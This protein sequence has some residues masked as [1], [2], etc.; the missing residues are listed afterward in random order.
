MQADPQYAAEIQQFRN[1]IGQYQ[2]TAP[3]QVVR[4]IPVVVHV[5]YSNASENVSNTVI[6]NMITTI[7]ED[8]RRQN[9]DTT[10]TTTAFQGIAVDAQIEFCLA[11]TDP[12]GQPTTGIT[13][14]STST[15]CWNQSTQTNSMKSSSTGGA[16]PWPSTDYLNIWICDICPN[17]GGSGVA[18]YAYLPTPGMHGSSIDGLVLDY[19]IGLGTTQW[20]G[21]DRTATHELGHYFG[22]CHPWGCNNGGCGDDDNI[23]DTPNSSGPNYPTFNN[24]IPANTSCGSADNVENY[25]DYAGCPNMF[26]QGQSNL[27]NSTLTNIRFSLLNSNACS[28]T[29]NAPSAAFTGKRHRDL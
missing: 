6:N 2:M 16:N 4:T 18:G 15:T 19:S 28:N 26:T 13:R 22:L 29:G 17:G 23:N 8:F 27:M 7:N 12:N 20:G 24:C 21:P 10:A 11:D 3:Q 14:T 9:A 5:V 25:M 1:N